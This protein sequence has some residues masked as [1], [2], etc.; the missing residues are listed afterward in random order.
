M[1]CC[2][3]RRS[4]F[5]LVELLTVVAI[6]ALLIG[7]LTPSLQQARN[8]AK[9]GK[10]QAMF[11]SLD[12]AC[13]MFNTDL[14]YY[15]ISSGRNPFEGSSTAYLTGAQWFALQMVGADL[16]GFV[17]PELANDKPT[18]ANG[19]GDN[20]IDHRDWLDWY[21]LNPVRSYKRQGKYVEPDGIAFSPANYKKANSRVGAIPAR[22]TAGSSIWKNDQVPFFV[23]AF[24]Q[25]VL[26]Y[27][28]NPYA[29]DP[30]STGS[31]ANL[32][33]GVYDQSDNAYLTGNDN[34][35][36]AMPGRN[37]PGWDLGGGLPHKMKLFGWDPTG[38]ARDARPP[39]DTFAYA[40][41]DAKIFD[42]TQRNNVNR[43]RVWPHNDKKFLLISAGKDA[44]Y[45]TDDDITNYVRK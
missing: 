33:Q 37:E 13:E 34:E 26:Y 3:P 15:P 16:R 21:S 39:K 18:V 27:V 8:Q 30:Y 43:G 14:Q 42:T 10:V 11:G 44:L 35:L 36:G 22:M 9:A 6:I 1:S 31:G 28:A 25:P 19:G 12:R 32:V 41:Y 20:I 38:N 17:S 5:T 4:G 2:K 29:K 40:T 24:N 23:D 45:G 7:I